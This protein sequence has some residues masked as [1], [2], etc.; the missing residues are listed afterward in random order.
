VDADLDDRLQECVRRVSP[1]Q[2][3]RQ[4][5]STEGTAAKRACPHG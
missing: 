5:C 4:T 1:F 3:T 2:T